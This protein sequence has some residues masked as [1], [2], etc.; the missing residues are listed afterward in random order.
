MYYYPED[1]G[2]FLFYHH[3]DCLDPYPKRDLSLSINLVESRVS[4]AQ[5]RAEKMKVTGIG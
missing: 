3:L 5:K 1:F 4:L 2:D